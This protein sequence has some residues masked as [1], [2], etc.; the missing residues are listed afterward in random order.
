MWLKYGEG[1]TTLGKSGGFIKEP[2]YAPQDIRFTRS[3]D[4]RTLYAILLGW[5]DNGRTVTV[6]SF[7]KGQVG[8]KITIKAVQVLGD[9]SKLQWKSTAKG[10]R[11]TLPN[12]PPV[13]AELATVLKLSL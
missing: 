2:D 8:E 3:K 10:L 11:I 5:P 6:E 12:Q 9:D 7:G 4:D 13:H 1:P